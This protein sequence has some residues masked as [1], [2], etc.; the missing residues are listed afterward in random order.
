MHT[1]TRGCACNGRTL[2][3][4]PQHTQTGPPILKAKPPTPHSLL[5]RRFHPPH[6]RTP[7]HTQK[8]HKGRS[9]APPQTHAPLS[10]STRCGDTNRRRGAAATGRTP[11]RK[12]AL[13]PP[14]NR[15]NLNTAALA[16]PRLSAVPPHRRDEKAE[17]RG[18]QPR[19]SEPTMHATP[20]PQSHTPHHAPANR[21][22]AA[23][24]SSTPPSGSTAIAEDITSTSSPL[25]VEGQR[26][27]T[28]GNSDC[29]RCIG[30][31]PRSRSFV[32]AAPFVGR[33]QLTVRRARAR[34]QAVVHLDP[35]SPDLAWAV[36]IA[37]ADPSKSRTPRRRTAPSTRSNYT[38][39]P[40]HCHAR[41]RGMLACCVLP[42]GWQLG[43]ETLV[44][45]LC[46]GSCR[47]PGSRAFGF[48]ARRIARGPDRKRSV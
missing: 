7:R 48:G 18:G 29:S 40:R 22:H 4:P 30:G 5:F 11:S 15:G 21:R 2:T 6:H 41:R 32:A 36:S 10:P 45:A 13:P 19:A 46:P 31:A 8:V 16:K 3:Q 24:L 47:S 25:C 35:R 38:N 26:D 20:K 34:V 17:T 44:S 9:R 42:C 37:S 39:L 14:P 28:T 23:N 27:G 33:P 12:H 43:A 1:C